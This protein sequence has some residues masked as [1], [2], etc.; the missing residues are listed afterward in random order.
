[1][2]EA[3]AVGL[4]VLVSSRAGCAVDLVSEGINGFTFDPEDL[5]AIAELMI[6][7]S[8]GQI[9]LNAMSLA[10]YQRI[11]DWGTNRFALGLKSAIDVAL[12]K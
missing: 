3:M 6:H 5:E 12:S 10:S 8:S 1:V 7:L 4:P 9:D 2:N 11:A